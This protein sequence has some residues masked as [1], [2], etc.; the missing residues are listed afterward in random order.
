[1][2]AAGLV[3]YVREGR[4]DAGL[5][6]HGQA[7]AWL[8]VGAGGHGGIH[9][10][11]GLVRGGGRDDGIHDARRKSVGERVSDFEKLGM[12]KTSAHKTEMRQEDDNL[13]K[14]LAK[15]LTKKKWDIIKLCLE[16]IQE[17]CITV[18]EMKIT[19]LKKMSVD[20]SEDDARNVEMIRVKN[21]RYLSLKSSKVKTSAKEN[22]LRNFCEKKWQRNEKENW[23]KKV[24]EEIE[25]KETAL[26]DLMLKKK[27]AKSKKNCLWSAK[28]LYMY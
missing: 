7:D 16:I 25:S 26:R 1:M 22:I 21:I 18:K 27:L 3:G 8:E 28:E 19:E 5:A 6:D 12:Q 14:S 15:S 20:W 2:G 13:T 9:V 23:R 10:G 4:H 17:N 24:D 11:G